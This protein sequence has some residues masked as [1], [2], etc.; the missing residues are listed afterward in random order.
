MTQ[1]IDVKNPKKKKS[2]MQ[3]DGQLYTRLCL[4]FPFNSVSRE[5]Q[6]IGITSIHCCGPASEVLPGTSIV[7]SSTTSWLVLSIRESKNEKK[8]GT[9]KQIPRSQKNS[10]DS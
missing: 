1:M 4:S 9:G 7:Q 5:L 10:L 3:K 8:L 2:Q 6:A